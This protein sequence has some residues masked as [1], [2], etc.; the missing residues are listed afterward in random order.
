MWKIQSLLVSRKFWS[1]IVSLVAVAGAWN[2]GAMTSQ[3]AANTAVA[4]LAAYS[5]AVS[6]EDN[7]AGNS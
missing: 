5:I 4:A 6:I 1:L 3:D 2:S 7:G